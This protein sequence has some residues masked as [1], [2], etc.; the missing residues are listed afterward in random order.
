MDQKDD[1][2]DGEID[3][4]IQLVKLLGSILTRLL[5]QLK[6]HQSFL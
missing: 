5:W 2:D 1:D 4:D 6:A 3:E